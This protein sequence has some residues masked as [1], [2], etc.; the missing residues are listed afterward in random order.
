MRVRCMQDWLPLRLC[1]VLGLCLAYRLFLFWTWKGERQS[2]SRPTTAVTFCE[3]SGG[4]TGQSVIVA[5]TGARR[6]TGER[7]AS[8]ATE[9]VAG[10][11]PAA[12][13]QQPTANSRRPAGF[14]F[15][16]L[17][18]LARAGAKCRHPP[19]AFLCGGC[20]L[21]AKLCTATTPSPPPP[22]TRCPTGS[23]VVVPRLTAS[24]IVSRRSSLVARPVQQRP[25]TSRRQTSVQ[26][27][28]GR[29]RNDQHPPS[30]PHDGAMP[31][32]A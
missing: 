14:S 21:L 22:G 31:Q 10:R 6:L 7:A 13:S 9:A 26:R 2:L 4:E 20:W 15:L 24:P 23:S 12:S 32:R 11:M 27:M 25:S 17:L 1:L 18:S 5:S 29:A 3:A 28:H 19:S 16:F 30:P 8:D